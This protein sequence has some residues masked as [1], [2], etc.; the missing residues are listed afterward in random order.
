L[1]A[2]GSLLL[3]FLPSAV[4]LASAEYPFPRDQD[5][6]DYDCAGGAHL[7]WVSD[8]GD[9]NAPSV[10]FNWKG[11]EYRGYR[12]LS[13]VPALK[14]LS[15]GN[16]FSGYV[17]SSVNDWIPQGSPAFDIRPPAGSPS[18]DS[19]KEVLTVYNGVRGAKLDQ[20]L[21][22]NVDTQQRYRDAIAAGD[23]GAIRRLHTSRPWPQYLPSAL[24]A[25]AS[26]HEDKI[27]D[28]LLSVAPEMSKGSMLV[29]NPHLSGY[30][31]VITLLSTAIHGQNTKL[32]RKLLEHGSNSQDYID[33]DSSC[34]RGQYNSSDGLSL[35]PMVMRVL[36]DGDVEVFDLLVQHG[37]LSPTA[38]P[39]NNPDYVNDTNWLYSWA[40]LGHLLHGHSSQPMIERIHQSVPFDPLKLP[41]S[42]QIL[43]VWPFDTARD[44]RG[45]AFNPLNFAA[46]SRDLEG[47][48]ALVGLLD[49]QS[50]QKWISEQAPRLGAQ[51]ALM[52]ALLASDLELVRYL[53]TDLGVRLDTNAV[54]EWAYPYL[55][56][57]IG[58][59]SI[60]ESGA[61]SHRI[62][63]A[64]AR[65]EAQKVDCSQL[66]YR[67]VFKE[68]I[69]SHPD[70][71]MILHWIATWTQR[72]SVIEN[73]LSID[74][75][76]ADKILPLW[77]I[78]SEGYLES[79]GAEVGRGNLLH[80][81]L[82][83]SLI[84]GNG[85]QG[86][87]DI[88]ADGALASLKLLR[89]KGVALD[90]LMNG[91]MHANQYGGEGATPTM[92]FFHELRGWDGHPTQQLQNRFEQLLRGLKA[93]PGVDWTLQDREGHTAYS[94]CL[95]ATKP[96][97]LNASA[98][99]LI[100]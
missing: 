98:C 53:Q 52:Q 92:W 24:F 30:H 76:L 94:A 18:G 22:H 87:V 32:I 75:H 2:A 95:E 71:T 64:D 19:S 15:V 42:G 65:D 16:E 63:W 7:A 33:A 55:G 3:A 72:P 8:G 93:I 96:V 58:Y 31:C 28:F 62:P 45:A 47:F 13:R 83:R 100:K 84:Y 79:I 74:R 23:L 34:T 90:K 67:E 57:F 66:P 88:D 61:P 85:R 91:R 38:D 5:I 49:T 25:A 99:E 89:S 39:K 48:K 43:R 70:A 81:V 73:L 69:A 12:D 36:L 82:S 41:E 54:K 1:L 44:G 56:E 60:C 77:A 4:S 97:G 59:W 11:T 35:I 10:V 20:Q 37:V 46:Y 9:R 78:R 68:V 50:L 80:G 17:Y 51:G 86:P 29:P 6:Q 14:W 21:C 40:V 27:V 26:L